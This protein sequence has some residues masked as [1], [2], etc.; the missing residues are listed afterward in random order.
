MHSPP[1]GLVLGEH[2]AGPV[3]IPR[4][5]QPHLRE[6]GLR[7]QL[8]HRPLHVQVQ[9]MHRDVVPC[10][11]VTQQIRLHP[12]ESDEQFHPCEHT[13][14]RHPRGPPMN[15][16]QD[17]PPPGPIAASLLAA[18]RATD[19]VVDAPDG[20]IVLRVDAASNALAT[21]MRALHVGSA[22]LLTAHN[23]WSRP[24]TTA[25]NEAAQRALEA[26]IAAHGLRSLPA[27]GRDPSGAWPPETSVLVF[28]LNR[29]AATM[30]ARRWRQN[31][32]L[33]VGQPGACCTLAFLRPTDP[34][35]S[36][37]SPTRGL[38]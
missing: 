5:H 34:V 6:R 7:G 28:D 2:H 10:E 3:P 33:W 30:L 15:F 12:V 19:Y 17:D 38:R 18:Y 29:E 22:A 24:T 26:E 27:Q 23:P 25:D 16:D 13:R 21:L 4:V 35:D 36:V 11:A 37:P 9:Q 8:A 1:V 20:P 31:A 32:F 14:R